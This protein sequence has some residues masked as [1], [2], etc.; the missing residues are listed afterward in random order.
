MP[1]AENTITTH[2]R[3]PEQ[4]A[5]D[6][7]PHLIRIEQGL[8]VLWII[9]EAQA[10]GAAVDPDLAAYVLEHMNAD[11]RRVRSTLWPRDVTP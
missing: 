6:A 9:A 2:A 1:E 11:A 7:E 10:S 5:M 4:R 3:T 8:K